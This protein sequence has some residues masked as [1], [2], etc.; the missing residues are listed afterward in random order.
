ME[1]TRTIT[2]EDPLITATAAK[3]MTGIDCL[4]AIKDGKLPR[5]PVAWVLGFTLDEIEPGRVTCRCLPAPGG[6]TGTV[7]LEKH[8]KGRTPY[9]MRP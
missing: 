5:P 9:G 7:T 2:W 8:A 4:R 3:A 1:R 6:R